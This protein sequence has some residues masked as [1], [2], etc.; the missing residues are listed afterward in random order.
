MT[1]YR[2]WPIDTDKEVLNI[3]QN[4]LDNKNL[5]FY[6]LGIIEPNTDLKE[7]TIEATMDAHQ[8]NYL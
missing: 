4:I 3:C 2:N 5:K 8:C 7:A 1:N 6:R